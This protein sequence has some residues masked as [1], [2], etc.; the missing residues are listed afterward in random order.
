M[1]IKLLTLF[2]YW[3]D[4]V[5]GYILTKPHKLMYYHRYMY[6]KYGH[7]YCTEEQFDE[8]WDGL[9]EEPGHG[10]INQD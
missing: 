8:Y 10:Y 4:F 6:E 1:L 7:M 3:F 9:S 5:V 2:Q